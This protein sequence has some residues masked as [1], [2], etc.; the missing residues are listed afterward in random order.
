MRSGIWK[1]DGLETG[2]RE[3]EKRRQ[4]ESMIVMRASACK[5]KSERRTTLVRKKRR[6]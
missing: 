6:E 4:W 3:W 2:M 5:L 1:R